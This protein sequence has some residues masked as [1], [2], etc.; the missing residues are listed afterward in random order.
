VGK[1]FSADRVS[2][3]CCLVFQADITTVLLSFILLVITE[4]YE[5]MEAG[6]SIDLYTVGG[7]AKCLGLAAREATRQSE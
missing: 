4:L 2:P 6:K 5:I 1:N 3:A 7:I